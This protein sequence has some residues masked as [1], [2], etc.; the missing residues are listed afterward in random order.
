[1]QMTNVPSYTAAYIMAAN[2]AGEQL[3]IGPI[4]DCTVSGINV[5]R[6]FCGGF[7]AK[8]QAVFIDMEDENMTVYTADQLREIGGEDW[9][10]IEH[11]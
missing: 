2:E 1:M 3:G 9:L 5:D 10:I 8:D 11:P 6:F 4:F 7:D